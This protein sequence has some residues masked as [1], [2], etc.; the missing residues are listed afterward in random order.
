MAIDNGETDVIY[1]IAG[2]DRA[3]GQQYLD[4][5]SE[6]FAGGEINAEANVV[7]DERVVQ[8]LQS[9]N[10]QAA[11]MAGA[12]DAANEVGFEGIMTLPDKLAIREEMGSPE[13]HIS[14]YLVQFR[15]SGVRYSMIYNSEDIT[16]AQ[17][18]LLQEKQWNALLEDEF[19]DAQIVEDFAPVFEY[20]G[21]VM[22][23]YAPLVD[24][25]PREW[26]EAIRD[27]VQMEFTDGVSAAAR[28]VGQG[29][30][31]VQLMSYSHHWPRY[32]PDGEGM[33][34]KIT[35]PQKE[36]AYVKHAAGGLVPE[37]APSDYAGLWIWSALM[38]EESQ[39]FIA[40]ELPNIPGRIDLDYPGASG[41]KAEVMD[42]AGAYT[43]EE[44]GEFSDM[45]EPIFNE[46]MGSPAPTV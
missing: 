35:L 11:A 6:N 18:E 45:A 30:A 5:I 3:V 46:V 40:N 7:G 8:E 25:E 39:Q 33:P 26:L 31:L 41:Y 21:I 1:Y 37:A 12:D 19:A 32:G 2:G 23:H 44:I 9:G 34:I 43:F 14:E 36:Y 38:E 17:E 22:E 20:Y 13:F 15:G 27:N 10:V 28:F 24:M 4:F 42:V 16:S 29:S